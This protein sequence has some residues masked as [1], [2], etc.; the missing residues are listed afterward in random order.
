MAE[1]KKESAVEQ[2]AEE[3]KPTEGEKKDA[4]EVK[5][6]NEEP[7]KEAKK[8]EKKEEGVKEV[9]KEVKP[10]EGEKKTAKE[11]KAEPKKE[12]KKAPSKKKKEEPKGEEKVMTVSLK[13]AWATRRN[14]RA[15]AAV[16][17]LKKEIKRHIKKEVKVDQSLNSVI[18]ERGAQK[19]PRTVKVRLVIGSEAVRAYAAK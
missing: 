18:W 15:N 8:E 19:P 16:R 1:E 5:T 9:A 4:K 13:D 12:E 6:A 14:N 3:V 11:V 7:K 17:V 2:I 10:T